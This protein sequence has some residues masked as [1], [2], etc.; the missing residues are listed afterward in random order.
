MNELDQEFVLADLKRTLA[1]QQRE[2]KTAAVQVASLDTAPGQR[3]VER[4]N[5]LLLQ[6]EHGCIAREPVTAVNPHVNIKKGCAPK[7]FIKRVI[8]KMIMWF[9]QP[10]VVQQSGYN[11]LNNDITN[12]M[13]DSICLL[14]DVLA[15]Q[16]AE[17]AALTAEYQAAQ[18]IAATQAV[19][20]S[21]RVAEIAALK[22]TLAAQES[23]LAQIAAL[24]ETLASQESRLAKLETPEEQISDYLDY[25][26]FEEKFR[27]SQAE[28]RSRI[29]RYLDYFQPGSRVLDLGCGRGEWMELLKE[30]GA[31]PMGV[32]MNSVTVAACRKKNL[33][34]AQ[35]DLF[36]YLEQLP[37]NS[38]DGVTAIQVIE[39]ITPVQLAQL[40][41]LCYN[42]LRFGGRVIF[43]TQNPTVVSTLTNNFL[44]DPT[45]IRPVHPVWAKYVLENAGFFDVQLDFP[46]YA[47]VTDGSIPTLDIPGS[48]TQEF[49]QRIA[50]LNNLLYGST[51]YAVIGVKR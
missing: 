1:V 48:E 37:D 2:E 30:K 11:Y 42:K 34:V 50:Y 14:K 26:A 43:E 44:V 45:H 46:Q 13:R 5:S 41:Q 7:R 25:A 31:E 3:W 23:R 28:I 18:G 36:H 39:H 49:N 51:D 4:V 27:G 32:D 12:E 8:R 16:Q 22:E 20:L 6:A 9:I 21:S 47:W 40:T 17:I 19:E 29:R 24:K 38:L 33:Q 10:I 35:D 15:H